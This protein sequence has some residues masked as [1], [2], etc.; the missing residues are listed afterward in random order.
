MGPEWSQPQRASDAQVK[1][2]KATVKRQK[3]EATDD[4]ESGEGRSSFRTLYNHAT[5]SFSQ[6]CF[7]FSPVLRLPTSGG[8]PAPT[9]SVSI[10]GSIRFGSQPPIHADKRRWVSR[11]RNHICVYLRSSAVPFGLVAA[12]EAALGLCLWVN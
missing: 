11:V 9:Q 12:A 5:T 10:R 7:R 1:G 3:A 8:S 6:R 2:R 4:T